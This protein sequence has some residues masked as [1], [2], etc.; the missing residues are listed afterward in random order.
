MTSIRKPDR[1][2]PSP[3]S[4][5]LAL[6]PADVAVRAHAKWEQ[7]GRPH[8]TALE[9]W[10]EAEAEIER[11][12]TAC[13][14]L[15][16]ERAPV[17]LWS[18]DTALRFTSIRGAG[19]AALGLRADQVVGKSLGEVFGVREAQSP[20]VAAHRRALRGEPAACELHFQERL[21]QV[22]VEPFPGSAGMIEE[23][24]GVAIEVA[25]PAAA[26]ALR[27][28][29][30]ELHARLEERA[31]DLAR[32]SEAL[33]AEINERQRA[34][35]RMAA[36]HAVSR[37]LGESVTL[38][39]AAPGVV[40]AVCESLGWAVG[41]L[42][43][44][45]RPARVLRC[46]ECR[47]APGERSAGFEAA[48]WPHTFG[49]GA[50][51]PGRVW[52]GGR[53][54]WVA[55]LAR[56]EDLVRA[57]VAAQEG[58][59]TA[60]AFPVLLGGE[61]LAVFEFFSRQVRAPN[62]ELLETLGSIGRQVGHF[63]ERRQAE[64]AV[65]E[66]VQEL[67]VARK[68]QRGL[69]P[70]AAPVLAGF[71]IAGASH[72][73]HETGGDYFDFFPLGD[74]DLGIAVGDASG[75]GVGAALLIAATRAYLRALALTHADV[76]LVLGLTNR[77][78]AEDV[79]DYYFV[80]LFL[81]RL[82]PST[83]SLVYASAGHPTG[84]VLDAAGAVKA[85]LASTGRP[86]GIEAGGEFPAAA[87]PPLE[88]GDLVLLLTDGILEARSPQGGFF[89]SARAL[90]VVRA[91]QGRPA[92]AIVEALQQSVC[93][94]AGGLFMDDDRTAVVIKVVPG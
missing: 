87:A 23:C 28:A 88:A 86:L 39:D 24:I 48:C 14:R 92:G 31:A 62:D 22:H 29:H 54:A 90:E 55:D 9:D 77:R 3:T 52:T 36:E 33:H 30:D 35:R 56:D 49:P 57:P 38:A 70:R 66:R 7:K 27:R 10:L 79:A 76:S 64:A 34:E 83:R 58:L 73:A 41:A 47:P 12:Q 94:F 21:Y 78:L 84:Y 53:V 63:L 45:D 42:W 15:L 40:Q 43:V 25:E 65:Q 89:G 50:G 71:E 85:P 93:D 46:L 2:N 44:V 91:T 32:I 19:L 6:R 60:C 82:Q 13:L 1:R 4:P 16:R 61:T 17:L 11:A 67:R 75:H 51:L 26:E 69:L 18:V 37:V 74:G 68:I 20:A 81:A 8:G 80:T 5:G 72:P 59:H